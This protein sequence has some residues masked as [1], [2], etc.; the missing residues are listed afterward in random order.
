LYQP[1]TQGDYTADNFNGVALYTYSAG[2]I[3]QVAISA[4]NGDYWKFTSNTVGIIP[5]TAKYYA[6][7]GLYF[8]GMLYNSSAQTTAPIPVS[9]STNYC[10][11]ILDVHVYQ[12]SQTDLAS[13]LTLADATNLVTLKWFILY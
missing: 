6:T 12:T 3:T 7:P 1:Y 4:N 8:V 9:G 5:F 2:V 11:G 10:F 13:S